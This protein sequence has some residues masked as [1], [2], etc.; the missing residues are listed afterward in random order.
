MKSSAT[1]SSDCYEPYDIA[2]AK[3]INHA[4]P[5]DVSF[6]ENENS[7]SDEAVVV[8][9]TSNP[10]HIE[11][12]TSDTSQI[13]DV[14]E[15]SELI[16][17]K[18]T[19]A[20]ALPLKDVVHYISVFIKNA[21]SIFEV[22]EIVD[23]MENY[24]DATILKPELAELRGKHCANCGLYW[25]GLPV[26]WDWMALIKEAK[27][28]IMTFIHEERTKAHSAMQYDQTVYNFLNAPTSRIYAFFHWNTH[29]SHEYLEACNY[30][31]HHNVSHHED[32]FE[33]RLEGA[34]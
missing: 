31:S 18:F 19:D 28:K 17:N 23:A 8:I 34:I 32:S 4:L 21:K 16:K 5:Q 9:N 27:E 12:S 11:P 15:L 10:K 1:I 33:K 2:W 20:R 14:P 7:S 29:K 26:T 24:S 3:A 30:I 25:K 22:M 6:S 13:D